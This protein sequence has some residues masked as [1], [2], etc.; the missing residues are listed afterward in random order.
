M[1]ELGL[2]MSDIRKE[3][4]SAINRG[5]PMTENFILFCEKK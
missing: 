3:E 1:K 5:W 4:R 2:M